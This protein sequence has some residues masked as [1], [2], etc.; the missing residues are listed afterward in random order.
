MF[1]AFIQH[2]DIGAPDTAIR[3]GHVRETDVD[4]V[5]YGESTSLGLIS[6]PALDNSL[7]NAVQ[8]YVEMEEKQ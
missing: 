7:V 8:L 6:D 4:L 3:A 1:P 5:T 2:S